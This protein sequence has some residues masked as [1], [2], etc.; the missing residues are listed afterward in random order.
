MLLLSGVPDGVGV[1]N[2]VAC[3]GGIPENEPSEIEQDYITQPS[4]QQPVDV[5]QV[6]RQM[7]N[8]HLLWYAVP[9]ENGTGFFY[10]P[11][12]D[13]ARWPFWSQNTVERHRF[14]KQKQVYLDKHPEDVNLTADEI[15]TMMDNND[16][17]SL[18]KITS[19]RYQYNIAEI[20]L[21][22][23]HIFLMQERILKH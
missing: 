16:V 11:F 14:Q 10:Y 15:Q 3:P 20:C 9:R 12:A 18:Q 5:E 19:L 4:I 6:L 7:A 2:G 23:M 1:P 21:D 8:Q 17:N 22:P 13:H